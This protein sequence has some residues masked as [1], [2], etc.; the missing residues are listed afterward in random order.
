MEIKDLPPNLT[1]LG[2]K[3]RSKHGETSHIIFNFIDSINNQKFNIS[4]SAL[5]GCLFELVKKVK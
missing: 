5:E 4:V 3:Y 2:V 1:L